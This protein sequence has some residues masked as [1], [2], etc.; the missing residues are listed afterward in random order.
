MNPITVATLAMMLFVVAG[1]ACSR[2]R[3]S[4]ATPENSSV[5]DSPAATVRVLGSCCPES[6][7]AIIAL[8]SIWVGI[9]E[10]ERPA[11]LAVSS[12]STGSGLTTAERMVVRD[13]AVWAALWL[14]IAGSNPRIEQVPKVSFSTEMLLFASTGR[15]PSG[16]YR[17]SNNRV[18]VVG[19]T[20][21]VA[22]VERR[23][24]P[25]CATAAAI[26]A[27]VALARVERSE[28]P[29]SFTT[30]AVVAYCRDLPRALPPVPGEKK[31]LS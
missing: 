4:G 14:R 7:S 11:E 15:K 12:Y 28:L 18:S 10:S 25:D 3:N 6:D 26:T 20:I 1:T 9:A 30:R 8:H 21:R 17:V 23:P 16:G 24:G 31:P 19:D 29:V 13:S 2:P 22:I 5:R 27:P